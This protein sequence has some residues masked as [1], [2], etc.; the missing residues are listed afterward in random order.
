MRVDTLKKLQAFF[1]K[2]GDPD[3]QLVNV[4]AIIKAYRTH[5]ITYN[6]PYV[7][8]WVR[9]KLYKGSEVFDIK[10]PGRYQRELEN[11]RPFWVEG[12]STRCSETH[13]RLN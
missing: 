3:G 8:Y 13:F 4:K 10:N 5:K 7:T 12:V 6:P 11:P 1:T 9:G 2:N